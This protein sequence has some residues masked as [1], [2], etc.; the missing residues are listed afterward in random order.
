MASKKLF[1]S[2]S[3]R[4]R[5]FARRLR[6]RLSKMGLIVDEVTGEAKGGKRWVEAIRKHIESSDAMLA[7]IPENGRGT[8]N[9]VFFEIGA[10]R[11]LDKPILAVIPDSKGDESNRELPASLRGML[12]LDAANKSLDAVANTLVSSLVAA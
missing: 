6:E 3:L 9:S 11:A 7:V 8:A 1:L 2:Y 10:A 12:V 5:E 4:D